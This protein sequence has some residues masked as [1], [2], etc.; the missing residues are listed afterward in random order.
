MPIENP[1]TT[2]GTRHI[3]ANDWISVREDQVIRPDGN[4]GIYGVVST[5]IATGVVA[6]T[7]DDDVYLVGQYRYPIE[8]YSW[9]IIEGGGPAT[10]GPQVI[11]V[12][13]LVEEAGLVA[14]TWRPLVGAIHLSNCISSEVAYLYLATD[15]TETDPNP[16]PTEIL[17]VRTVPFSRCLDMVMAGEITD[18]MSV[19]GILL[20]ARVI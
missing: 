16:D 19:M 12:R 1:W 9:E 6:M 5:R 3:Y 14:A 4:P 11:A 2:V 13:E 7:P 20:T 18:A 17:E 8:Q 15:L 10:D